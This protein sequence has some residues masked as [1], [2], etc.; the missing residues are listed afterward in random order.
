MPLGVRYYRKFILLAVRQAIA[1]LAYA[2]IGKVDKIFW[3]R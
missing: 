1:A 2:T 3:P